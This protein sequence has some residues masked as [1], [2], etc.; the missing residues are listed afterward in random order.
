M[1]ISIANSLNNPALSSLLSRR[2]TGDVQGGTLG[3][4]DAAG[5]FARILGPSLAGLAYDHV[6]HVAPFFAGACI[7]LTALGGVARVA[8]TPAD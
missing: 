6:S 7:V 3:V 5:S 4:Q 8:A 2:A 1:L